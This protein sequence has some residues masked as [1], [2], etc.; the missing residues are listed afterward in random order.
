MWPRAL[1]NKSQFVIIDFNGEYTEDQILP[2]KDKQI[3]LLD[4][5]NPKHKLKIEAAHFW[6]VETLSLLFQAT[7]NTQQPFLR[8]VLSGKDKFK[9][10][11]LKRYVEKVFEK[12]FSTGEA[13]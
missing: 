4:S 9:D 5:K 2:A 7:T 6:D 13:K 3:T 8:R 1:K 11:P 12:A 10:V